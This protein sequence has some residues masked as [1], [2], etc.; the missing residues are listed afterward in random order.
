MGLSNV[1]TVAQKSNDTSERGRKMTRYLEPG[2]FSSKAATK[3]Y[4]DNWEKTFGKKSKKVKQEK[5]KAQ[6][7]KNDEEP[8]AG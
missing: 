8:K 1:I 4:R 3:D 7:E 2:P 6:D 5:E